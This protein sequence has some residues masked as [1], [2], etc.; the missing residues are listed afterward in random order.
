MVRIVFE[1]RG[2]EYTVIRNLYASGRGNTLSFL[3][4]GENALAIPGEEMNAAKFKNKAQHTTAEIQT[5]INR[6]I[7][8]DYD[9][10]VAGPIMIPERQCQPD[11]PRA[12]QGQGLAHQAVW[13]R[14]L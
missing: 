13:R 10:V 9:S 4:N 2:D 6:I 11:W 8:L 3:R 7:G 12:I 5:E 1:A 14:A